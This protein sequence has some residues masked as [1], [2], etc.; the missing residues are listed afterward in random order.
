MLAVVFFVCLMGLCQGDFCSSGGIVLSDYPRSSGGFTTFGMTMT[1]TG[2]VLVSGIVENSVAAVVR[3]TSS[4][5]LDHSFSGD[6]RHLGEVWILGMTEAIGIAMQQDGKVLVSGNK[7]Y[8]GPGRFPLLARLTS[9]GQLDASFGTGGI[10]FSPISGGAG[11]S[12]VLQADEKILIGAN[13]NDG[14]NPTFVA[15]YTASGVLD[16][17]FGSGT[18][19]VFSAGL[20]GKWNRV[21][22]QP[23]GRILSFR[24]LNSTT[25]V[26]TRYNSSGELDVSFGDQG[27]TLFPWGSTWRGAW[28]DVGGIAVQPDGK[29]VICGHSVFVRRFNADGSVDF[30]FGQNGVAIIGPFSVYGGFAR[31]ILVLSTGQLLLSGLRATDST[32]TVSDFAVVRLWGNGTTDSSFGENGLASGNS[33]NCKN[34]QFLIGA[35]I[36]SVGGS[37]KIVA[38]G[39]CG[40]GV[41]QTTYNR[42][43]LRFN[44]IGALECRAS[45]LRVSL[46]LLALIAFLCL[47]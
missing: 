1:A 24:N 46:A 30:S 35:A 33:P 45:I 42:A 16:T 19:M 4:G 6:G 41:F 15:R 3:Y 23:D 22:T 36:Q 44:A 37:E 14:P 2:E 17:T 20:Y 27:E 13:S 38:A 9:T 39:S 47:V 34:V 32:N 18:G 28:R 7:S 31:G 11:T 29:I 26:L 40:D 8:A 43:L 25:A 12:V 21:A 10:V 5:E